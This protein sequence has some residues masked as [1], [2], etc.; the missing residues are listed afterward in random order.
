[1]TLPCDRRGCADLPRCASSP[2]SHARRMSAERAAAERLPRGRHKLSRAQVAESQ[3]HRLLQ[4][5]ADALAEKGYTN[6][7]VADVLTRA[8]V[9]RETFYQQF[10]S[11]EECFLETLDHASRILLER[12]GAS[13]GSGEAA[14][15]G[16]TGSLAPTWTP[17]PPSRPTPACTWSRSTPWARAPSATGWPRRRCSP[18]RWRSSWAPRPTTSAWPARCWWPRSARW[19]PTAWPSARPRALPELREPLAQFVRSVARSAFGAEL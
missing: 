3:R 13:A 11:K 4:A 12:V 19:S 6:T 7:S 14:P 10:P 5:M 2:I 16:S 1:M 18:P 15:R 9:S 8:G 17:W